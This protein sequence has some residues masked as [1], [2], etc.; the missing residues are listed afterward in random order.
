ME[1]FRHS[2]KITKSKTYELDSDDIID[3]LCEKYGL[4]RGNF[5]DVE[6]VNISLQY[7]ET[8]YE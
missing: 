5:V 4:D 2:T 3:L 8:T 6:W 7:E 1:I